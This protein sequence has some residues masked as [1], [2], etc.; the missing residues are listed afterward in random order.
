M[1]KANRQRW[2]WR[3]WAGG[4]TFCGAILALAAAFGPVGVAARAKAGS[5]AVPQSSG[6]PTLDQYGGQ[7]Q[8]RC[9]SGA[10]SHF[11][12]Y[13]DA[14]SQHWWMCDPAGNRFFMLGVEVVD[15]SDAAGYGKIL[16]AKYGDDH[17]GAFGQILTRLKYYGFNTA[18]DDANWY[19]L[20]IQTPAGKGNP[21]QVPFTWQFHPSDGFK[22]PSFPFKDV[23]STLPPTYT[24]YRVSSFPDVFDP[25]F[26]HYANSSG[27]GP[28][29]WGPTNPFPNFAALDASP[30]FLGVTIDD[31]D[32]LW[33]FKLAQPP[34]AGVGPHT[35]WMVAADAS[36]QVYTGR[37]DYLY[38][39]PV[40][41]NKQEWARWLQQT[42]DSGPGYTSINALN[43]AW[44]ANYSSFG[45]SGI[46]V[47]GELVGTG[48]GQTTTFT[49][50]LKH[51]VMDPFSLA[52][53][54]GTNTVSG[55]CPWFDNTGWELHSNADCGANIPTNTGLLGTPVGSPVSGGSIDYTTGALTINFSS[56]PA[57]GQKITVNYIYGGWP[58]ALTGGTGL[59]DEDGTN[60]WFPSDFHLPDLLTAT[61][62]RVDLDLDNFLG[63]LADGYFST[64]ASAIRAKI[65]HHFVISPNFLGAYDRPVI[66]QQAAKRLDMIM[67]QDVGDPNQLAAVYQLTK[68][69]I[70]LSERFMANPDSAYA[71][72]PCASGNAPPYACQA[73]QQARGQ[74][75]A[76]QLATDLALKGYD[77]LGYIVGWS[78]WE[79]T[80]KTGE[81]QNFGLF[82]RF[83]NAYDGIEDQMG[84]QPC[85]P[86][87][88]LAGY[89]CG[90]E[91]G[92]YGDYLSAV[93]QANQSW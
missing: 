48:D 83:D 67:L 29:P 85:A 81:Q 15:E 6:T 89:A 88:T 18:S 82:S 17:Y 69:P 62:P 56:P 80:D 70:L 16:Q 42:G 65:P 52:V 24:G 87:I 23:V 38:P 84:A 35:G 79:M 33:G 92:N 26:A 43:A 45:S 71:A 72:Y 21:V 74:A 66:F 14:A 11:Y 34:A 68:K 51:T 25:N 59:L 53:L 4:L 5:S 77:G 3:L 54:V 20:P 37:W 39:D 46:T 61:P 63:H 36:Y 9:S 58:H 57:A 28:S 12:L 41:H 91:L 32:R 73:T 76:T 40:M 86:E 30:W 1:G 22:N 10:P 60:T 93:K 7:T 8:Y 64:V 19:V 31:S 13:K 2:V 75:Y 49:Y 47:K 27:P 90:G 50:T 55:D 44:G 78:Y